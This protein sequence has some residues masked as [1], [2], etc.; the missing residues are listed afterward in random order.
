MRQITIVLLPT[1]DKGFGHQFWAA[2]TGL[3]AAAS[4]WNAD[5]FSLLRNNR[6]LLLL[7]ASFW[8]MS[9][10]PGRQSKRAL[11]PAD[12][13]VGWADAIVAL[14]I[15]DRSTCAGARSVTLS[16]SA[17]LGR[18]G[19]E[20]RKNY[21]SGS[22]K[23]KTAAGGGNGAVC[24]RVEPGSPYACDGHWCRLAGA[25]DRSTSALRQLRGSEA[26]TPAAI[27]DGTRGP[28]L[29]SAVI[30]VVWHMR[31]GDAVVLLR[32]DTV[33]RLRDLIE[34]GLTPLTVEH[35][36]C[37]Y[38]A[39]QLHAAYPWL[40]DELRLRRPLFTGLNVSRPARGGLKS[41]LDDA[42]QARGRD[43]ERVGADAR[44]ALLQMR[45]ADVLISTGSSFPLAA[46]SLAPTGSQLHYF[47]PPKELGT[48]RWQS[49]SAKG[50]VLSVDASADTIQA[51]PWWRT[52]FVRSNTVPLDLKGRVFDSYRPK[53]ERIMCALAQARSGGLS[54]GRCGDG[55]ASSSYS[56]AT[57]GGRGG[58]GRPT[59]PVDPALATL[60]FEAWM[61]GCMPP[62]A[63]TQGGN[64]SQEKKVV[65]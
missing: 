52:Y 28:S 33:A 36:L 8:K 50:A 6:S 16:I 34:T 29:P 24:I 38:D 10:H 9:S 43:E 2:T 22:A 26:A 3:D 12:S 18:E 63:P 7:D 64:R 32:R 59:W 30:R 41:P 4:F 27:A 61:T 58:P 21:R 49:A 46:A 19:D 42:V 5:A 51:T 60:C 31:T 25:F 65:E 15:A 55:G 53:A 57:G 56:S 40:R 1:R 17:L 13:Y 47:F 54:G 14:P 23:S 37:T 44:S 11:G 39:V 20:L 62:A 48:M 35:V 45:D